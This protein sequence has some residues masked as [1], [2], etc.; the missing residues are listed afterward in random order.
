VRREPLLAGLLCLVGAFVVLVGAGRPWSQVD[1]PAGPLTAGRTVMTAGADLAPGLPALG[2]VGLA[3]V[4]ALAATRRWGRPVVGLLLLLTG[5]GVL[6]TV[7][8]LDIPAQTLRTDEV[9]AGSAVRTTAWPL[10]T[11]LGGL[12]L[13]AAGLLVIARGRRW[14]ALGKRYEVPATDATPSSA[15]GTKAPAAE[16]DLWE[17]LDRGEDPTGAPPS[18]G[19]PPPTPP[20]PAGPGARAAAPRD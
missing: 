18:A 3:G 7:L 10:V 13:V 9:P 12:L 16:R 5:L 1:L 11:G 19:A 6:G 14:P 2:L 8:G 20:A 15:R 17:A 4:V